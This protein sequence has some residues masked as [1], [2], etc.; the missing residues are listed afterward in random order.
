[1]IGIP[2]GLLYANANEWL[3]HKYLLH[4]RGK[5]KRSFWSFHWHD[6][7]N[8][9]RKN[10]MYD[11]QYLKK[12]FRAWDPHTKE[13]VSLLAGAAVVAPLL[14]IAPFFTAACW[15]STWN[16][17]RVHKRAH[18][19]PAW[20]KEHLPWHYDHH[21]GPDQ[22]ANWCVSNPAFDYILGTRKEYLGTERWQD[23]D[24]RRQ[25]VRT[26]PMAVPAPAQAA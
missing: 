7:H 6:H 9:A 20:A 17:Y 19:D 10:E 8:K 3:I 15:W 22:D 1:M 12:P 18:L 14:P 13:I 4:D 25:T 11:E 24:R 23:D 21:M 16:Y 26:T 2:L 5:K